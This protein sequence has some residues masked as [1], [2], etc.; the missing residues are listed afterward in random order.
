MTPSALLFDLDG[1]L[2]DSRAAITEC[3]NHALT[4]HGLPRRSPESLYRFIGP[5]SA[6]AFAEITGAPPGSPLVAS[7]VA[8]YRSRYAVTS[9]RDTTVIPGVEEVVTRL[10]RDFRLAV[11]TSKPLAFAEPLLEALGLR[12]LF[13]AVAGPDVTVQG[14]DKSRT[15]ARALVALGHPEKAVM[16]GD[17]SFDILGARAHSLPSIGVTWGVGDRRELEAAG[18]DAIIE[19]PGELPGAATCLLNDS[20]RW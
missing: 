17:R 11:A 9:L 14:E 20:R 6:A 3:I 5:P 18:A 15:I 7:C 16:I 10:A 1:V 4:G 8:A 2:V 19:K 13:T 12:P